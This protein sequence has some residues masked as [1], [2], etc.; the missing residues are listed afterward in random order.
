MTMA[1]YYTVNFSYP[2]ANGTAPGGGG[3]FAWGTVTPNGTITS[4]TATITQADGSAI[5]GA[6]A[7]GIP[8]S[9]S[10][11]NWGVKL[12]NAYNGGNTVKLTVNVQDASGNAGTGS[13]NFKFGAY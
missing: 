13:R 8:G 4:C 7:V 11:C 10:P 1:D 12:E 3:G 2:P 6:S 5:A 9:P